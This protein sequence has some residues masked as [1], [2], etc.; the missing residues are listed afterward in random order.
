MTRDRLTTAIL[1]TLA[2]HDVF[3]YPLKRSEL[4]RWLYF[5]T[6]DIALAKSGGLVEPRPDRI[7]RDVFD[8]SLNALVTDG[9]IE[10]KGGYYYFKG[11]ESLVLVRLERFELARKKWAIARRG[12]ALLRTTPFI[13]LVA[14][15]NTLAISNVRRDSD[16]DFFIITKDHRLWTSRFV[17]T[18]AL[19]A[20]DLRRHG[21][22]VK[23]RICLS[24]YLTEVTADVRPLLLPDGD[25][26]FAFWLAQLVPLFDVGGWP[27]SAK[28]T[29][30]WQILRRANSWL[31]TLM[32]NAWSERPEPLLTDTPWTKLVRETREFF[33][34]NWFG[35]RIEGYLKS[36]QRLKMKM[37]RESLQDH[38]DNRVVISM[39]V[40]KAHEADRR[41]EYREKFKE[42]LGQVL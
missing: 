22:K 32:P 17:V 8:A 28:A 13:R 5:G 14:V 2:Y 12:A 7:E 4:W 21:S 33:L 20:R 24:F 26:Y 27:D 31:E 40:M 38:P 36:A 10:T 29:S 18:G 23:D 42:R 6:P 39:N 37:N 25:P 35:E 11:R 16:I 34:Y 1:A 30:G 3:S 19:E 9:R 41:E 15:C